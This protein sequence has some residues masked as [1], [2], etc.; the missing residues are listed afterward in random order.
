MEDSDEKIINYGKKGRNKINFGELTKEQ[1]EIMQ[2][3]KEE[4]I[5]RTERYSE[6]IKESE[7]KENTLSILDDDS[8]KKSRI[9][10]KKIKDNKIKSINEPLESFDDSKNEEINPNKE[11]NFNSSQCFLFIK[12]EPFIVIGPDTLYYVYIFS[13]VSFFSIIIYSLKNSHIF[14]KILYISGYLFFAVTYTLLLLMN[15]GIPTNK[16]KLDP[17]MLQKHYMQCQECNSIYLNNPGTITLHCDKCQVCVE[18][19]DHHCSFATKC[20]GKGNV[21][22]F[23]IWLFSIGAFF[24]IIFIYLIF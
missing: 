20:I 1:F 10:N 15:P 19:F 16:S 11:I 13:I 17:I 24:F 6:L 3:I 5:S 9:K 18:H 22:L 4:T 8:Q 21:T 2:K 7:R 12:N 14:F 23:K